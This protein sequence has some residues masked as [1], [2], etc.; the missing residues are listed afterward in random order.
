MSEADTGGAKRRAPRGRAQPR[1]AEAEPSQRA[2]GEEVVVD[3]ERLAAGGDGIAHAPDGRVVFVPASAPGDRVRVRVVEEH[4]KWLRGEIVA[5]E[6]PGPSRVEPRCAL[7]GRCGG[8]AWQ[9]LDYAAQLAA[10]A[11]ILRDAFA[12]IGGI[13][14]Q[15]PIEVTPSPPYGYRGRARVGVARGVVGFRRL[16]SHDLEPAA[17]CPVLVPALERALAAL[18]AAPPARDGEIELCAGAHGAVRAWGPGGLL[19]GEARLAIEAGPAEISVSPGVFF[20][21]NTALRG[22]LLEA[23]LDA[24]GRGARA[25]DLCA[26]AGFFTF[27]LAERFGEVVAVES[28]PPAV[29]DLRRNVEASGA[30]NVRVECAPLERWLEGEAPVADAIVAD[31]PRTGLGVALA[32]RLAA[33][34]GPARLVYVSCAPATLARDVAALAEDGLRLRSLRGFDLFP[35]TAHVE[36]VAVLAR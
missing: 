26:G 10:K 28:S 15:E 17:A 5:L 9:H 32:H 20:Q 13:A 19:H 18:A 30:A 21:G 25:L 8:C 16:R 22:A 29:R 23:V 4:P 34:A 11:E 1:L 36:A 31:P 12:R 6:A 14:W 24:A 35:Q 33:A 2:A 3:I 27:G 7:F